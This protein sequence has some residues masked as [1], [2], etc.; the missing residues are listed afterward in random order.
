MAGSFHATLE[1]VRYADFL[2]HVVDVSAPLYKEK[3][4][5]V[6]DV[7]Q[8]LGAQSKDII[9]VYNKK[10]LAHD[11][12]YLGIIAKESDDAVFVSARWVSKA[13]RFSARR[14]NGNSMAKADC[15]SR[16]GARILR[17][18]PMTLR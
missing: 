13:R 3:E 12:V 7:L 2:I 1:E 17:G 15:G 16:I 9:K 11:P 18:T 10:D 4:N 5:A 6:E 14:G 8:M